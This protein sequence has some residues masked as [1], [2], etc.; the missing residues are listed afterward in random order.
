MN[1]L[2]YTTLLIVVWAAVGCSQTNNK[3]ALPAGTVAVQ[4]AVVTQQVQYDS[5]DPAIWV[6]EADPAQSLIIGVDKGD[7]DPTGGGVYAFNL[8]GEVVKRVGGLSRLNN[9]DIETGLMVNGNPIDIAVVTER[10]RN[11]LR[12]YQLPEQKAVDNGGLPVFADSQHKSPMGVALYKRPADGA[13]FAIVSRKFGPTQGYLYQYRLTGND[14]GTVGAQ[15]VRAFGQFSGKKE[16]EA[17]CVD[18]VLGYVYYSDENAGIRKYYADPTRGNEEL[19]F[20]GQQGFADDHEGISIYKTS[21][22][23]GYILVSD[24]QANSFRVFARE[25]SGGQHQH[26][27][28]GAIATATNESDG[29]ETIAVPLGSRFPKGLFVAMSDDRTFQLYPWETL[30]AGFRPIAKQ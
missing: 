4:P 21:T 8:N 6:N 10:G 28:L 20:F 30:W 13:V 24:Q 2:L 12:V 18:D 16:I 22:T 5:D 29:S 27:C 11:Q 14:D 26:P 25:G 23:T 15:F 1:K 9:V 7:D 3:P 17:I 19:A